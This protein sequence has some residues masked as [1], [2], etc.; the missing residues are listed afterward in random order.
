MKLDSQ[1]DPIELENTL[2]HQ[3]VE[4]SKTHQDLK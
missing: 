4:F 2:D 3:V 1:T